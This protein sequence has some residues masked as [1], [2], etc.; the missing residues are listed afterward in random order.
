[1]DHTLMCRLGL[2]RAVEKQ[3]VADLCCHRARC[4]WCGQVLERGLL[5]FMWYV[6][7]FPLGTRV[8]HRGVLGHV[9]AWHESRHLAVVEVEDGSL[10][11]CLVRELVPAGVTVCKE[12]DDE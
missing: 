2:H 3:L 10:I 12:E 11:T 7:P 8:N 4:S 9:H 1:M 5:S 6:R